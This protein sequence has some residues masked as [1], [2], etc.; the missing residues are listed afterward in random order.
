V[1]QVR[2]EILSTRKLGAYHSLTLV[3]PEIAEKAKPGQYLSVKMPEGRDFLL[4]RQ[5]SIHQASRR[6]GWA[7]TLE[8]VVDPSGAGTGW[9]ASATAHEFLEVIGPLGKGFAYPKRLT[10]CLLISEGHSAA[11]LYLLAQELLARHKR[12]DMI[13]GG[14]TLERVFKPIEAKRLSQTVAIMTEDG[15]LGERGRVMDALGE[16]VESTKT[17]VIYAA[18]PSSTLARLAG[19]CREHKIPAQVLVEERMG[20]GFGLCQTCVV[21]VARKDGSGYDHIRSCIEGPVFNPA[22]V[23]WDRWLSEEPTMLP[24]PPEGLPV[25]RSWPG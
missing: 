9:L 5:F 20:C 12:V 8:F 11:P 23:L 10:N 2:A 25:V 22:R 15:S 18:A 14:E 1:K 16:I 21:P 24:T 19:F 4:R 17:E 3:A 13:V 6:G 7:G